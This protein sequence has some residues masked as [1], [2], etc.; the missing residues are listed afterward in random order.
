M[1]SAQ[2]MMGQHF[3]RHIPKTTSEP[4]GNPLLP[5]ATLEYGTLPK[6]FPYPSPS[7]VAYGLLC[8]N[9]A[10][11]ARFPRYDGDGQPTH[12]ARC[13]LGRSLVVVPVTRFRTPRPAGR[14]TNHPPAIPKM[15]LPPPKKGWLGWAGTGQMHTPLLARCVQCAVSCI[16]SLV[17]LCNVLQLLCTLLRTCT[18]TTWVEG[19][20]TRITE[21]YIGRR[22][23]KKRSKRVQYMVYS[24]QETGWSMLARCYHNQTDHHCFAAARRAE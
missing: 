20:C 23:S 3:Y 11:H 13:L 22:C 19:C 6:P 4:A 21:Y 15:L 16:G 24:T 17:H 5:G 14:G 10:N 8:W 1:R 2:P 18:W 7:R 12:L 9:G